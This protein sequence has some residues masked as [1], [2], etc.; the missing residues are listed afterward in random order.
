MSY[1]C[2]WFVNRRL[3]DDKPDGTSR[4]RQICTNDLLGIAALHFADSFHLD[5]TFQTNDVLIM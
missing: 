3:I 5:K 2:A 1:G 4:K